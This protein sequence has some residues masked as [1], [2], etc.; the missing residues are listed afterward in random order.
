MPRVQVKLVDIMVVVVFGAIIF[1]L[2]AYT[3]RMAVA[4]NRVHESAIAIYLVLL[5]VTALAAK[6]G[7][8]R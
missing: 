5:C 2:L 1:A 3:D 7:R 6:A 8:P 4:P